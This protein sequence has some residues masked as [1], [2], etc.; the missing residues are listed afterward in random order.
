MDY[1]YHPRFKRRDN[2]FESCMSVCLSVCNAITFECLD[3]E[4]S[5]SVCGYSLRKYGSS[6][7]MKVI[8]SRS[9]SQE[10]KSTK[11]PIPACVKLRSAIIPVHI[12]NS[13]EVCVQHGVFGY[14][15]SNDVTAV[16]VTWL[17]VTTPRV[18]GWSALDWKAILF[19][20]FTFCH[21]SFPF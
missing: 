9:R 1:L 14:G 16:I 15:R 11:L 4:S 3:A 20:F 2:G 17:K 21:F 5:F 7:Y 13:R 19:Y 8:G 6:S 10:H 18:R 12:D